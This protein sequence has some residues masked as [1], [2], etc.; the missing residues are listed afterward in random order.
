MIMSMIVTIL[1][2]TI[3]V[4]SP[5]LMQCRSW[6]VSRGISQNDPVQGNLLAVPDKYYHHP[7]RESCAGCSDPQAYLIFPTQ[8]RA[9]QLSIGIV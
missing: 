4:F 2:T 6:Q 1:F 7:F 3:A 9:I 8:P 5:F